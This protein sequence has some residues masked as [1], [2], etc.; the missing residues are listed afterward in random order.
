MEPS[1]VRQCSHDNTTLRQERDLFA[2]FEET[3]NRPDCE[4]DGMDE[5]EA[6]H[7]VLMSVRMTILHAPHA[8]SVTFSMHSKRL[9]TSLRHQIVKQT[10]TTL[11]LRARKTPTRAMA[12]TRQMSLSGSSHVLC[13]RSAMLKQTASTS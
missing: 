7:E 13:F 12:K 5:T 2:V 6:F 10:E 3:F 8:K 4:A 11:V 1:D 9:S